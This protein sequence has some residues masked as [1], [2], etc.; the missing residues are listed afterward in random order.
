VSILGEIAPAAKAAGALA[1]VAQCR[2][3][4]RSPGRRAACP[5][6]RDH[7]EDRQRLSIRKMP[8]PCHNAAVESRLHLIQPTIGKKAAE[9]ARDGDD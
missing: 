4:L 9:P 6:E 3:R 2:N 8:A 5:A 7:L 1:G